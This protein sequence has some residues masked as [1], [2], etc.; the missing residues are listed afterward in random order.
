MATSVVAAYKGKSDIAIG[1]V[2]GSNIF[3]IFWILG[4]SASI[5]PLPFRMSSNI[6]IIMA[7]L[8]SLFLFLFLFIGEKR[9]L[10]KWQG[11]M[12]I[13]IYI[14]YL[15]YLVAVDNT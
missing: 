9:K 3:N 4:L 5:K 15:S 14:L 12:F 2:V 6:D 1:N 7:S 13:L 10:Q 8:A 11:A